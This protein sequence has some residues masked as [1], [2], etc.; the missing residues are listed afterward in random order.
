VCR[1]IHLGAAGTN[2]PVVAFLFN[3]APLNASAGVTQNGIVAEGTLTA[4]SLVGPMAG[5]PLHVLLEALR[6]GGAYVNVHTV[7]FP[8]GG[9]RGQIKPAGPPHSH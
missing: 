3:F 1:H 4:A 7:S 5:Q 6:T 9:V 8:A 2:G